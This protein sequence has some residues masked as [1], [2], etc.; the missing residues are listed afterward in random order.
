MYWN[1]AFVPSS[2]LSWNTTDETLTDAFGQYGQVT[3]AIVMKDRETGRS[4]GFGFVTFGSQE[5]ADAAVAGMHEQDLDGRR[6]KV[7]PANAR[8]GGGGGGGYGGGGGGGG[9]GGGGGGYRGGGGG[10]YGGGGYEP[11]I[12]A[13]HLKPRMVA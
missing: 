13:S 8:G 11:R 4:R 1:R 7:N 5:E 3:D 10:N 2:N 12:D 6:I 9:Y